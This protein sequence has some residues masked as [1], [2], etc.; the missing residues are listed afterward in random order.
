MSPSIKPVKALLLA[1][2]IGVPISG[3]LGQVQQSNTACSSAIANVQGRVAITINCY[4]QSPVSINLSRSEFE[5]L[6]PEII[7]WQSIQGSSDPRE[8]DAYLQ[9]YP[10]GL[11]TDLAAARATRIR[12]SIDNEGYALFNGRR[13]CRTVSRETKCLGSS[14][15]SG[16]N[17]HEECKLAGGDW[18]APVGGW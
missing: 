3:A 18:K 8:Y 2:I 16:T 9:R 4:N 11:F 10:R 12:N 15:C 7:F 1:A 5:R 6:Q 13:I 17:W 14:D